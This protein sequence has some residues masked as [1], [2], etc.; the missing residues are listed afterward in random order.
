[1]RTGPADVPFTEQCHFYYPI[2][3]SCLSNYSFILQDSDKLEER[4]FSVTLPSLD[5][6]GVEKTYKKISSASQPPS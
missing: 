3:K 2:V 6:P 4:A 5:T 1:M